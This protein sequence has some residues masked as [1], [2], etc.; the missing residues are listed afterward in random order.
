MVK[1]T[2]EQLRAIMDLKH[3]IR[4][5]SVIAHVDHGKSTLTDSLVS[6]AGIIASA[7]AGE[8]RFTDTRKDEQ[9]RCITIKSTGV[10][11]YF[12][13]DLV[14]ERA[15]DAADAAEAAANKAKKDKKKS[16]KKK[17]KSAE[18]EAEA[19]E[20]D[21]AEAADES[22]GDA[23]A[24]AEGDID[25]PD[26]VTITKNSF[27]INL[28]DSPGHVDFSSEVTAALRVTDGA[29]VVVDCIE[30]VCVQTET[31]LRQA[32]QER[33]RPVLM[34]NKLDR[35]F[36]ELQ[37]D[38]EEA[39][40][41]F[42]KAVETVNVIVETYH[43]E[44]LGNIQLDPTHGTVAFGSGLH[45]WGFTLKTFAKLYAKITG[46]S[47][48][49]W[50]KRLWG[51]HFF[52][53][54]K[55]S[56]VKHAEGEGGAH[57]Q[58][59]F[60]TH[61]LDKIVELFDVLMNDRDGK[62]KLIKRLGVKLNTEEKDL[63]EKKL[64]KRTMQKWLPAGDAVLEMTVCKLPSPAEA[65]A[66]RTEILYEGPMDDEC[67]VAMKKC[68]AEGPLMMYVSKMV[69]TADQSRFFAFGRVFSGTI[70][71]GQKC[72]IMGPNYVPGKKS[73]L[74]GRSVERVA[75]IPAGNTCGLVG[76]DQYL[77]KTGTITTSETA[78][79]I[80][81]MK[82]SV[83]AVVRQAVKVKNPAD[84]KKLT[85]GLK[86]LSKSDPL[87]QITSTKNGEHVI[88]GAGELHLEICLKDLQEDF[89]GGAPIEIS[90]PVVSY[91]ETVQQESDRMCLSKSANKHNRLFMKA[92][93]MPI[94]MI[95]D[96]ADGQI[97][98][99]P[100]DAK[101][102]AREVV[103]K[104]PE[105]DVNELGPKKLW[106]YGPEGT[107]PNLMIDA[108][109]GVQYLNEIKDHVASGFQWA[110]SSGPL[111][112]EPVRG[113]VFR[114]YDA[115]LHADAIHRG[116]GQ[117][118]PTTRRVVMACMLTA[119]PTLMEPVYLADISV[120]LA[121]SSGVHSALNYQGRRGQYV[122]QD[123]KEGTPMTN[124]RAYLPV[125]D[126][127][128]FT[129]V[130][131]ELTGGKAFPQCTFDHWECLTGDCFDSDSLVGKIIKDTRERKN[132]SADIPPLDRYLDKL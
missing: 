47:R 89:M 8:A 44:R 16:K 19:D 35:A 25:A 24:T 119:K 114:L 106:A 57:L 122:G 54:K 55:G 130:L 101:A 56:W 108:S 12:E 85:E 28:I 111:C 121:D 68:D 123:D 4:N 99:N 9:E 51:N 42:R 11:M 97:V 40:Q 131:R 65:Q 117:I 94:Q 70:A 7:K 132:L 60:V 105:F 64:L 21:E 110:T 23:D 75:D 118:Q 76:V 69:P 30:G 45:Q 32:I 15:A 67:A 66:Y 128:G 127:F 1:F 58:R 124:M 125:S 103:E 48:L 80:R 37:M 17:K 83:S 112:E 98:P 27:L 84:L 10:S 46:T 100:Q 14:T 43:D 88:A 36:L 31:V 96:I 63:R 82:Y 73:D 92:T 41:A 38:P 113:V 78:H 91:C 29:L 62:F 71:T 34:L 81:V 18:D 52:D 95:N 74:M 49:K 5:M 39:Y 79:N 90:Q 86:R 115:K 6:K 50:M 33:I 87:V 72:R 107:G 102:Q 2:I 126:S 120:P 26:G 61:I 77:L 116:V 20:A 109:S 93:P 3:N 53:P 129:S 22:K 59:G 13:Y 104:Y